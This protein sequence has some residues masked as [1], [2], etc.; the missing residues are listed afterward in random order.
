MQALAE[1]E[2]TPEVAARLAGAIFA[3]L[4]LTGLAATGGGVASAAPLTVDFTQCANKD[5]PL[6]LGSCHW[7]NSILQQNNSRYVEGMSTLQRL[8][9]TNIAATGNVHTLTFR[10]QATKGWVTITA[11]V[12][13]IAMIA[14][15]AVLAVG[16]SLR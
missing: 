6:P 16:S 3:G 8:I 2:P 13:V 14:A 1:G 5:S 11:T 10:H 4:F 12:A 7:I 15:L 9:F